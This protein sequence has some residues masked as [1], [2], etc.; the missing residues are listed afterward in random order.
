MWIMK[1][2]PFKIFVIIA[3]LVLLTNCTKET[4]A[5]DC[6]SLKSKVTVALAAYGLNSSTSNCEDLQDAI[7]DYLD[8]CS[9]VDAATVAYFNEKLTSLD[10]YKE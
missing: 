10:C 6:D 9:T 3:A 2:K 4:S 7:Y 5:T 1:V 8:N